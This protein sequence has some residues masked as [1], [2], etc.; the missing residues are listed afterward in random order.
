[1][2]MSLGVS[3]DRN[4]YPQTESELYKL[5]QELR[6]KVYRELFRS[7]RIQHT[8]GYYFCARKPDNTGGP[9]VDSQPLSILITCR[10]IAR[11]IGQSWILRESVR[12]VDVVCGKIL[13]PKRL[14]EP[15]PIAPRRLVDVH[16][17]LV[18]DFRHVPPPWYFREMVSTR[19][20]ASSEIIGY[21][22]YARQDESIR[23]TM[24]RGE[25]V[26]YEVLPY[27]TAIG[28][29]PISWTEIR[30][31]LITESIERYRMNIEEDYP[32]LAA[33]LR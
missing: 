31:C 26:D 14:D 6:D 29:M 11:E 20:G 8:P 17:P 4:F 10:C 5:S 16:P 7:T 27:S 19:E 25:E 9:P 32:D 1:M 24:T 15:D 30:R 13:L 21:P 12:D 2:D 22:L 28:E 3:P 23:F 18:Y 33:Y